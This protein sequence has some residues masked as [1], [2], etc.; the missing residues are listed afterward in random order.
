MRS[1]PN[2]LYRTSQDFFLFFRVGD[3]FA[4]AHGAGSRTLGCVPFNC[5]DRSNQQHKLAK[6]PDNY[7]ENA[8]EITCYVAKGDLGPGI[9]DQGKA[10][11]WFQSE[12]M[13][14]G[15]DLQV[16]WR[17]SQVNIGHKLCPT[18]PEEIL[19]PHSVSD[20]D[21]SKAA[22]FRWSRRIPSVVFRHVGTGAVLA[23]C[24]QP[25]VGILGWR[26][27]ED[28]KVIRVC[29]TSFKKGLLPI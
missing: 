3:V 27:K 28:E 16:S 2:T 13:R 5:K 18:Y 15:F 4:F 26:S 11:S 17:V 10:A 7:S 12:I 20:V 8:G 24:S 25:E 9:V 1:D 21:L 19:V 22:S 29:A 23:R 6:P 14:L